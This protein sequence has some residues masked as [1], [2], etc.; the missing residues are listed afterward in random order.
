MPD[1][2]RLAAFCT[3]ALALVLIPGPNLI[4]LV[5]RSVAQGRRAGLISALGVETGTLVH[6]SAA[7]FGLSALIARSEVAF[8]ALKYAGAGYLLVLGIRA[9]RSPASTDLAGTAEPV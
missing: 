9:L 7:A 2:T 1:P 4:Y 6:I 8:A 5:T 3:A